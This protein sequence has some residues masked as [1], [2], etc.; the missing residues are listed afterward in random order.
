MGPVFI[1]SFIRA[2]LA[3]AIGY[4]LEDAIIN[5]TGVAMPIGLTKDPD[6]NYNQESGY[7]DLEVVKATS[8]APA[9]Y[10]ALVAKMATNA[11]GKA[12][13]FDSVLLI[14]NMTDY[15]TKVMP[16]TTATTDNGYKAGNFPFATKVIISNRV[17]S[18]R[19]I[20]TLP[21]RYT[22][23]VGGSKN[24]AIEYDDSVGFL[25]R[26]RTFR[27]ATHANGRS[28]DKTCS[29]VLDISALEEYAYPVRDITDVA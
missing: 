7:P 28:Y 4:G 24:G 18:N 14:C 5:G 6:G 21:G 11:K 10:G 26:T 12:R 2:T 9:E 1:D 27:V 29:V 19:A 15:L 16:A 3:E 13:D 17:A 8:F 20:L 23:A 22:L 25:D